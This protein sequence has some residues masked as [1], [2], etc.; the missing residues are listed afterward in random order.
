MTFR[1]GITTGPAI[2]GNVG[3]A[4]LFNYTAIGDTVNLAQRLQASAQ[5]G[6]ILLESTTYEIIKDFVD[7][8]ALN[9]I[10]VKGREQAAEVYELKGLKNINVIARSVARVCNLICNKCMLR[11]CHVAALSSQ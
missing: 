3:T 5:H 9:P 2:I 1:I 4:E 6:Q 10:A 8:D 11:D 7:A